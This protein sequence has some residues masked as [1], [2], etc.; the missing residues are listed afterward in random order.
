MLQT[1]ETKHR[2]EFEYATARDFCQI[3]NQD[4]NGLYLLSL[5]L[6]GD[7]ERAEQCFLAALENATTRKTVF[8]EWARSWARR[9][10][11]QSAQMMVMPRAGHTKPA[12]SPVES[13]RNTANERI[14]IAA[15]LALEP[16]ERLVF[17]MS[18]LE[19]YSSHECAILLGSTLREVTE[20]RT[21]ALQNLGRSAEALLLQH[22]EFAVSRA[23]ANQKPAFDF[24]VLARSA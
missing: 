7:H 9:S 16:F 11:I 3:F 23:F 6:T 4:I 17:V 21:R 24:R 13:G 1:S 14:E 5:L 10:V 8:K 2:N 19:G 22:R 18:V 20:A 12:P 15:V